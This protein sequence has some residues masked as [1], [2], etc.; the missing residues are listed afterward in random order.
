M[1]AFAA[2][3]ARTARRLAAMAPVGGAFSV[4]TF[5]PARAS[6]A[7]GRKRLRRLVAAALSSKRPVWYRRRTRQHR[8]KNDVIYIT[9]T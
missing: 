6:D 9:F 2:A 8:H 3:S 4:M 5:G 1:A 7:R